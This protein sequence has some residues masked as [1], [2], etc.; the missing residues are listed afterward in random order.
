LF[1][2]GRYVKVLQVEDGFVWC[3]R[4]FGFSRKVR[5]FA[6]ADFRRLHRFSPDVDAKELEA[7]SRAAGERF[8]ISYSGPGFG[9]GALAGL[10]TFIFV[11]VAAINSSVGWVVGSVLGWIPAIVAAFIVGAVVRFAWPLFVIGL[12]ILVYK[13]VTA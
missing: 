9:F 13:L 1:Q 10:V 8:I 3:Q 12:A 5:R 11:Y 6:E 2:G 4:F 7:Q